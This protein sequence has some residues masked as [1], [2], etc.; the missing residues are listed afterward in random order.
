M[1]YIVRSLAALSLTAAALTGC[2]SGDGEA[3]KITITIAHQNDGIDELVEKSGLFDDASYNVKF[4]AF[5]YGPPLVQ[6]ISSGKVDVG[7]VGVVPPITAAADDLNFRVS[8]AGPLRDE[9]ASY[10]YLLAPTGSPL[11][12]TAD[13]KG[14]KIA[15]PVGSSAHGFLLSA[16]QRAGLT[17]EDVQIVD[18]DPAKGQAAFASGSVDAWAIWI[19]QATVAINH[20]NP[21]IIEAGKRPHDYGETLW[22][23]NTDSLADAERREAVADTL[24]RLNETYEWG[25]ENRDVWDAAMA[26]KTGVDVAEA[27][28][29]VETTATTLAPVTADEVASTQELADLFYEAG[30]IRNPVVFSDIVDNLVPE[31]QQ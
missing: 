13:L 10:H 6:A 17:L 29:L 7:P 26:K 18:L 9:N 20:Q 11:K 24:R 16:I 5:D 4:A 23:T 22:V 25:W 30:A 21:V 28:D 1:K 2:S 8:A 14:K 3:K 19:P 15:V 12:T 31:G 27:H